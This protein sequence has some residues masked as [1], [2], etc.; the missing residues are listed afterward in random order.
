MTNLTLKWLQTNHAC[1]EGI[2]WFTKQKAIKIPNVL[3]KLAKEGYWNWVYWLLCRVLTQINR[4]RF[5]VFAA[6]QVSNLYLFKY[7]NDQRVEEAI[8]AAENW[9]KNTTEENRQKTCKAA[10]AAYAAGADAATNAADAAYAA[11]AAADATAYAAY[12]VGAYAINAIKAAVDAAYVAG[13]DAA[14]KKVQQYCLK[15]GL[16]LLKTN[17]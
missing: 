7:P 10:A 6:K 1:N 15:F 5:A 16:K 13:A 4:A 9:I 14:C 17:E 3:Q 2:H 11:Y 12:A 8:K